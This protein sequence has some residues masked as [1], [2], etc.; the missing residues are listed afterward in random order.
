MEYIRL[1][2]VKEV[3][4][5]WVDMTGEDDLFTT[6][7]SY[8]WPKVCYRGCFFD[9]IISKSQTCLI[10]LHMHYLE[11]RPRLDLRKDHDAPLLTAVIRHTKN[12][13]TS[14]RLMS[15]LKVTGHTMTQ[16]DVTIGTDRPVRYSHSIDSSADE[17]DGVHV[18][19]CVTDRTD[20]G[21]CWGLDRY[22]NE[23]GTVPTKIHDDTII[24]SHRSRS[25]GEGSKH[26]SVC[27]GP[28]S[29]WIRPD[30][31]HEG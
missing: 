9:S 10:R 30:R 24:S 7:I 29:I 19:P 25:P 4:N 26:A 15:S 8:R 2:I 5:A 21:F 20:H 13:T 16:P 18:A 27:H 1:W 31:R 23:E 28:R 12:D 3:E 17:S 22:A 6:V 11:S 14:G